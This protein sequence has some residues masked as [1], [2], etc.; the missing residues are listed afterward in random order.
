MNSNSNTEIIRKFYD[1]FKMG[2]AETMAAC[3]HP[4]VQF[5]DPVFRK[6]NGDEAG[7]MWRMLLSRAEDLHIEYFDAAANNDEGTVRWNATYTFS[8]TG[9]KVNNKVKACF[10]FKDGQIIEHKDSFNFW[11]WS[12]M[13]L[14]P[15]GFFLGFTP[16]L[17]NKV[18]AQTLKLLRSFREKRE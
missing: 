7:D 11:K 16:F 6:L 17:R 8:K 18:S 1:A 3:Y 4:D 15:V 5:E 9:R 12:G 14:G 2:D 10:R 13:A